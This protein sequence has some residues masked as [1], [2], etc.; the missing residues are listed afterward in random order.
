[1]TAAA[2]DPDASSRTG[3]RASAIVQQ[4]APRPYCP[5]VSIVVPTRNEAANVDELVRRLDAVPGLNSAEIIFVDD[6]TDETP[7]VIAELKSANHQIVLIHRPPEQRQGGLGGAVVEGFRRARAPWLAV[8][9][10]DLQHPP[11][12]VAQLLAQA[13]ATDADLVVASR[14]RGDGTAKGLNLAREAVSRGSTLLTKATFPRRLQ[15][16]SDPMSG[17]FLVRAA[18]LDLDA[19]QPNGFKV[20]LEIV[21]R[22]P[23]LRVAEVP[24]HFGDRHAGASKASTTEALRLIDVLL[25]LRFGDQAVRLA[26]FALVGTSGLVV[27]LVLLLLGVE[28]LGLHYAVAAAIGTIGSTASNFTLTEVWVF[29]DRARTGGRATRAGLF[30]VI[31]LVALAVQEPLLLTLTELGGLHYL[32]ANP[33]ALLAVM[34]LRFV[35]ADRAVWVTPTPAPTPP[36]IEATLQPV[37]PPAEAA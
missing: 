37:S 5:A 32:I 14:Y 12:V 30:L 31:G 7:A 15:G 23:A 18:C 27:N 1:M 3:A 10:A 2:L 17:C 21:G 20:L 4:E 19:L 34:L 9:D 13:R 11:A 6:S 29:G 35:A 36:M 16:V 33:I 26:R 8:M 22:T 25:R 24:Y 28:L